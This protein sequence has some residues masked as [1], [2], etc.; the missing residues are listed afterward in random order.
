MLDHPT[1]AAWLEA[2]SQAWESY[3]PQAIADLFAEDATYYY[4][5]FDEEPVSGRDAIVANWL[6]NKDKP[7]RYNGQYHPIAVDGNT[8]VTNGR[9]T[10]YKAD[11]KTIER[12]F[13][14]IFVLRFDDQGKCV[15]FREW[16]MKPRGAD[17]PQ[18]S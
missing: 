4:H 13:D 15:E 8:A 3:D 5:P 12:V 14:N 11:G 18:T 10:Y 6:E 7:G 2:Y 9:S 17:Y 16:Y 1:V